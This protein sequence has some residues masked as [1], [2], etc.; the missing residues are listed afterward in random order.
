MA[1]LD[2]QNRGN[3]P[4]RQPMLNLPP[5][6]LALIGANVLVHLAVMVLPHDAQDWVFVH[7]AFIPI[8][9]SVDGLGG[10][11]A[12]A[13]PVTYQFLH[14]GWLHLGI[15]MVML[16]AFGSALERTAGVRSMVILYLAAGVAG[17]FVHFA[18]FPGS[19]IPVVGASGSISGLFGAV[20]WLMARPD[21]FGRRSLRFW[22]AALI[23]IGVS[24]VIGFT[25]M[26]GVAEGQIAWAAHIGGF[27]AGIAIMMVMLAI[28]KARAKTRH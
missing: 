4:P 25:G 16:A 7:F 19:N 17:A 28:A 11:P 10:W 27:V 13:G 26:P 6:V 3:P 12:W 15:N 1:L 20:L 23:W 14:G 22:P 5:A 9:Y 18:L 21:R 24:V 2:G 8:R